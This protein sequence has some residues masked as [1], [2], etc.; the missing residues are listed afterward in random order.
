MNL[1]MLT[2]KVQVNKVEVNNNEFTIN[3]S[4]PFIYGNWDILCLNYKED[5]IVLA[6]EKFEYLGNGKFSNVTF[7]SKKTLLETLKN[8]T[9]YTGCK[10]VLSK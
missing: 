1:N 5:D 6:I 3:S 9:N 8:N 7:V 4:V 10:S 2:E